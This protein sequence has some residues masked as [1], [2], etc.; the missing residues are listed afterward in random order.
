[1]DAG[2]QGLRYGNFHAKL[3]QPSGTSNNL[4]RPGESRND[5]KVEFFEAPI[6]FG[7][8]IRVHRE[9]R[10]LSREALAELANL[11][12]GYLGEVE[13]GT[14]A[15]SMETLLRLANALDERLSNVIRAREHD[16]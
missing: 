9:K 4:R 16:D 10:G 3:L 1:M 14:F 11:N 13:R 5:G 7:Q 8:I 15:T 2:G 6:K 12:R